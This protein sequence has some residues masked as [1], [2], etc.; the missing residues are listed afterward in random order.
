MGDK[1]F[2]DA[3][4]DLYDVFIRRYLVEDERGLVSAKQNGL[5]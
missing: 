4:T 3:K 2:S 1:S 5:F